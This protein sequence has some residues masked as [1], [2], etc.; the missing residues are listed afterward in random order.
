MSKLAFIR[1]KHMLTLSSCNVAYRAT[2]NLHAC[3]GASI[4]S[5]REPYTLYNLP[6]THRLKSS[7]QYACCL[8]MYLLTEEKDLPLKEIVFLQQHLAA[9]QK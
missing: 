2:T 9:L 8:K 4:F 3:Y 5:I 1:I 6:F 7:L